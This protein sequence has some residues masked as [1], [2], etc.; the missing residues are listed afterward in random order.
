MKPF[1][2]ALMCLAVLSPEASI[3]QGNTAAPVVELSA[4]HPGFVDDATIHN[5]AVGGSV[6]WHLSPRVSVGP[7]LVYM[8]G[9]RSQR[10]VMATGNVTFDLLSPH[11]ERRWIPFIVA[12]AGLF[13][14]SDRFGAQ[15][16][17]SNE[18]AFTVGAGV[19]A[20]ITD[21]WFVGGEWRFGWEL[22]SRLNGIVGVKLGS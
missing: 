7:E 22:H 11:A 1:V 2:L 12:G 10:N 13:R 6:R 3:A 9:P 17:S 21:C 8:R 18:G 20:A 15:G 4:G 14:H 16:F 19:R 5:V